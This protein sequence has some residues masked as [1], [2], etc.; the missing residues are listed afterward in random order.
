M[1]VS[2]GKVQLSIAMGYAVKTQDSE[3]LKETL[4][5]AEKWMYRRKLMEGKSYRSA[6]INTLLAALFAKSAETEEHAERLK[7]TALQ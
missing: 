4:K 7:T 1:Q 5:E 6:I 3:S 2:D